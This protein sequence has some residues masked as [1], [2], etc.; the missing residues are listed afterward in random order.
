VTHGRIHHRIYLSLLCVAF[1]AVAGAGIFTHAILD[2]R[3]ESP[4]GERL[5]AEAESVAQA[6]PPAGAASAEIERILVERGEGLRLHALLLDGEGAFIAS[7]AHPRP[8]VRGPMLRLR[9]RGAGWI[10]TSQGHA[11]ALRLADGR[12]L[13][14]WT[15]ASQGGLLVALAVFFVLLAVGC[16][17]VARGLTR[18]LEAL[19]RG[20]AQLGSGQLGTRVRVEGRD[21]IARLAERFNWSADRIERLVEAERRVLLFASHELRSPLARVRMALELM[22]DAGGPA[23]EARVAE[24]VAEIGELDALV[25][26]ILLASRIETQEARAFEALDLA[27]IVAEEAARAGAA[28]QVS[29]TPMQ[30]DP[31]LLRRLVRNLVEN[32]V[33]H[34]GGAAVFAGAAPVAGSP[35]GARLWVADAGPGIPAAD[36]ERVFEPFFRG[37]TAETH[38]VGLG[39]ALVRQIAEH[40]GGHAVCRDREGG[41]VSF[42]VAFPSAKPKTRRES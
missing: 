37:R 23:I 3:F 24:A 5:L 25:D 9:A 34:G 36:R 2:R 10:A 7:T 22:R 35:P 17:P 13:A 4:Y 40:H 19:E 39:L 12:T 6:L 41:G 27:D 42:E 8:V 30:G 21:E 33:R 32:A 16:L 11:L 26:D 18:R 29:P 20:V 15:R 14:V 38:G 31:R 1:L 28:V